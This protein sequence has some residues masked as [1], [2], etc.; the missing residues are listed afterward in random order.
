MT[1]HK[2]SLTTPC[3]T[4][5]LEYAY[6]MPDA[7]E[8]GASPLVFLHEGLGSITLWRNFP[9][10][11]CNRLK[12]HGLT[13]SRYGYG[14]ST[15]RPQNEPLPSDYLE[16]EAADTLPALLNAL[17][18]ERPWLIGHSDGGTIALLAAA[19]AVL[20]LAGIIVIAPHYYVEEICL[21]GIERARQAFETSNLR[22]KMARYHRDPDSVFYGWQ[23]VWSDPARRDWNIAAELERIACPILAIQGSD[24]EYATLEQIEGIK[25]RAPQTQLYVVEQCGHFPHL[26]HSEQ[27]IERIAA[28]IEKIET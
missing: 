18:I 4:Q 11:L 5:E 26:T 20:P 21:A 3:R 25:R 22:E 24:D 2:I 10:D 15:P 13:Y 9:Q 1:S 12:H 28:F 27:T 14:A 7:A 17:N 16:H 19:G 8:T 6:L 23:Q